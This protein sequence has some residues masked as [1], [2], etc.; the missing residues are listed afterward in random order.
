MRIAF[1]LWV[2]SLSFL[3][4][5]IIFFLIIFSQLRFHRITRIM[6]KCCQPVKTSLLEVAVLFDFFS[7]VCLFVCLFF[8]GEGGVGRRCSPHRK[9]YSVVLCLTT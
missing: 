7:F 4:S 1:C 5:V 8:G 3:F 9:R 2:I 6:N